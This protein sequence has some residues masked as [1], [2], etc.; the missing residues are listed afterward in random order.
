MLVLNNKNYFK[1]PSKTYFNILTTCIWSDAT[2]EA[3]A[4]ISFKAC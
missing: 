3:A 1:V 4:S 2:A